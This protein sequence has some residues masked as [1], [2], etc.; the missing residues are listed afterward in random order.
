MIKVSPHILSAV[1]KH[2]KARPSFESI[3]I[4]PYRALLENSAR[5]FKP[6]PSVT[7]EPFSMLGLKAAWLTPEITTP[8]NLTLFVH[9]GGYIAGS[10]VSHR[11]LAGRIARA[12]ESKTL[13]VEYR[14]APEN[15]FPAG[16]DDIT[17]VYL[18]LLE[19][20]PAGT[21]IN[22]VGDSAGGGLCLGLLARLNH[23]KTPLPACAVFL[24]PWIDLECK[25]ASHTDTSIDDPMLDRKTLLTTA[26]LYTDKPLDDPLVSPVNSRFDHLCPILIHVGANEVLLDDSKQ[27]AKIA[28]RSGAEVQLDIYPD[29]FH[30]WHYFARYLSTGQEAIQKIG[31]FIKDHHHRKIIDHF[32]S[33][34]IGRQQIGT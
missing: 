26:R 10:I 32:H 15:P 8:D 19:Q 31:K 30:V 1:F 7:F 33:N 21:A 13:V 28:A 5:I 24:S 29:M 16:L 11:D 9:G 17:N 2:L 14:L 18:H 20:V 23:G 22:L 25:N 12:A 4:G 27:L 34:Q 3:G 6:D